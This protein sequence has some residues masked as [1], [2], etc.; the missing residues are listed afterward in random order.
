MRAALR[1]ILCGTGLL[2]G[3]ALF[4]QTSPFNGKALGPVGPDGAFRV[5]FS[6]HFHGSSGNRTGAPAATLQA[7]ID[8][9]NASGAHALLS[10]GDLFMDPAV[11]TVLYRRALFD[12][13]TLPLF[14]AVGNHDLSGDTYQ[15]AF[16]NTFLAFDLGD[17]SFVVLDTERDNGSIR[18]EQLEALRALAQ[19]TD[20]KQV[21]LVSHRPVWADADPTYGPLFAGN[22][23]SVL[24]TNY[25]KEVWPVVQ[26]IAAHTPVYWISGSMAGGA[27]A[28][29]FFQPH[30]PNIT[31]IQSAIRDTPRDAMLVADVAADGVK[32][33]LLPLTTQ[34]VLAAE[35]LDAA[36]WARNK[37][38]KEAF[39][40][41][42]LPYL[43]KSTVLHRNFWWGVLAAFLVGGLLRMILRRIL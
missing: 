11:D 12:R 43:V 30:A 41:R 31:F 4:A 6:G 28:S 1:D 2:I 13:L 10:T 23:R 22:T 19:R 38:K 35:A 34:P 33:H 24:G 5:L 29:V 17:A 36:Y 39:N 32:W 16:G 9:L 37:G 42:L 18:G 15:Q 40:W 27:P 8:V 20:R 25:V 3:A 7:N 14:N 21:F 26:A